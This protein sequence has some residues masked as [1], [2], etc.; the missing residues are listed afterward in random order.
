[1]LLIFNTTPYVAHAVPV[2][3]HTFNSDKWD[4]QAHLAYRPDARIFGQYHPSAAW[5]DHF[6]INDDNFGMYRCMPAQY[7]RNRLM[8]HFDMRQRANFA[9]CF[10]PNGVD[11]APYLAEKAAVGL[12]N[13]LYQRHRH[14]AA[15]WL[16]RLWAQ[17]DPERATGI[18]T[19]TLYATNDT[20]V[21]SYANLQDS[22]GRQVPNSN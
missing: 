2:V 5:V 16:S 7:L 8:P 4:C 17:I 20:Y 14:P 21:D 22:D 19:R 9:E 15:D 3:G 11:V 18:V 6:T 10:V 13:G 1:V 12:M